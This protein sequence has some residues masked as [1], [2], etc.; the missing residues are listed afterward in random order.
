MAFESL[1]DKLQ[2]IFKNLRGKGRL[3][4]SDVKE[5]MKEVKRALLEADV[6]F[7]VVKEFIKTVTERSVGQDVLNGLNPAQMVIKIVREEM[8]Q[9]M[10][11]ETTEIKLLSGNEITVLLMAGLQGAGKTTTTAKIAGKLKAKGKKPLLV[12]C[13]VYRPA[14]IKQLQV[15]GEKQ[16]VPVFSMGENHKPVNIAKAAMEHAKENGNNV[17]ILDTAGR[18]HVDED[19]M[20]ELIEI[21]ENLPITQTILVVD[22]MTGQDAVNVAQNFQEKVGIDG[23]ILTKLDGDTRGGAALSIRAV[24]GCPILYIGMGEKLDDLQQFYPDR[25]TSRILGMGDVLTL[26]D[27]VQN[28]VD[29]EKAKEM[30]QKFRKAE[31]NFDDYLEQ[32]SQVKKMGGLQDILSM[33]PGM[34]NQLKDIEIDE[35]Q[36]GKTEAIIRSMTK[37]ERANPDIVNPSRK[38]RIAKGAGVDIA[39]VNKLYKQ[40]EQGRK[41]MKQMSG[42]MG[43]KKKHGFGNFKLPFGL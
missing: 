3:S 11:S 36:I 43:G 33:L 12:A 25:M 32:M 17:V 14:A 27:K 42:M 23:V 16:G 29:E 24:T 19:M 37:E 7:K 21:K 31:F 5:A 26:I 6:N 40:F 22:A 10:G 35:K 8:E 1:S 41:M 20:N 38:K 39:D 18:L 2:N 15:N 4:E 13:D 34:G 30:E 28:A 9:L